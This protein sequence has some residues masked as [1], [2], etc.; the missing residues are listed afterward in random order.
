MHTNS[1]KQSLW[2]IAA[3]PL[4]LTYVL[5]PAV[6]NIVR[7]M[8][9]ETEGA[10]IRNWIDG[11]WL[12]LL[13]L[14]LLRLV[15][16]LAAPLK[17]PTVPLVGMIVATE[18]MAIALCSLL[19]N[20][21]RI[22]PYMME[23]KP[24]FYVAVAGVWAGTF[25]L[26]SRRA[27]IAGGSILS[28]FIVAELIVRSAL[29][30][31]ITHPIGSGEV[32]YDAFLIALSLCLALADPDVSPRGSTWLFVGV[33][34][35]FSRTGAIACMAILIL[36]PRVTKLL[37]IAG[38]AAAG[39]AVFFSFQ[40]RTLEFAVWQIDRYIMWSTAIQLFARHPL[41]LLF[42]YGLGAKLPSDMPITLSDLWLAQSAKLGLDGVFAF[43][44]HAMWLRLLISW[45]CGFV[46]YLAGILLA[47]IWQK[48]VLVARY[49]A[50]L[51]LAEAFT[52]GVFYLSNVAVPALFV[53]AMAAQELY[54]REP[55]F[56]VARG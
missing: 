54:L 41:G 31:V 8:G 47:W 34:A 46:L 37:K 29:A 53:L 40:S 11:A 50:I 45:G 28:A 33:L 48:R 15:P 49:T 3:L 12:L 27:I 16:R 38:V 51:I 14:G 52:M 23:L 10:W 2:S 1:D 44:F 42:G 7:A 25:G 18:C 19:L 9:M 17:I 30:G 21:Q 20:N 39:L 35:S 13:G 6:D 43:H 26:P 5:F 36:S 22:T 24:L 32:N 4:G 56:S 55:K